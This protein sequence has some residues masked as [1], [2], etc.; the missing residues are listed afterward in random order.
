MPR[1]HPALHSYKEGRPFAPRFGE[2]PPGPRFYLGGPPPP[3]AP[4]LS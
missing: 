3:P 2:G 1:S 4:R